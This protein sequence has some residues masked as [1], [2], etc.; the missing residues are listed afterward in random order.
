MMVIELSKVRE[1]LRAL[2]DVIVVV[3]NH[4]WALCLSDDIFIYYGAAHLFKLNDGY[5][6][7]TYFDVLLKNLKKNKKTFLVDQVYRLIE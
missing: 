7:S 6:T 3:V 1:K 4:L 2:V 5:R